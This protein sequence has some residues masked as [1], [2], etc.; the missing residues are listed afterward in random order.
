MTSNIGSD[1]IAKEGDLSFEQVKAKVEEELKRNFRLEFLNRFDDVIVFKQLNISDLKD[2]VEIMINEFHERLKP[3]NI[4]L[5]VTERFKEK[6]IKEG[7]SLCD[8][9]RSLKRAVRSNVSY[10]NHIFPPQPANALIPMIYWPPATF[11]TA[12][13]Y[14]SFPSTAHP[15]PYSYHPSCSPFIPDTVERNVASEEAYGS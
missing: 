1:L 7:Y 15:Q 8:G 10:H 13:D 9:A 5:I 3:K 11:P 14:R 12:Y 2:I 6:L 4:E